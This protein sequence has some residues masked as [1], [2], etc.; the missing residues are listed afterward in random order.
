MF[1]RIY[2][3]TKVESE[4]TIQEM[5]DKYNIALND[6]GAKVKILRKL[7]KDFN[8]HKDQVSFLQK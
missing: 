2:I 6:K 3:Y 1:F 7:L 5:M 8:D 4:E